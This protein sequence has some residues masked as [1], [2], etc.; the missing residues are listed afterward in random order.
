MAGKGHN[1]IP[2]EIELSIESASINSASGSGFGVSSGDALKSNIDSPVRIELGTKNLILSRSLDKEGAEGESGLTVIVRCARLPSRNSGNNESD[3]KLT[4]GWSNYAADEQS[5]V[6]PLRIIV[7]DANDHHPQF[8]GVPYVA[9]VSEQTPPGS[10]LLPA[11]RVRAVDGDQQGPFSTVQYFVMPG[12]FSHLV[13]FESTLGG[14]L[15]LDSPLDFETQPRV[16]VQ[17]KACDQGEPPN[18]A[19]E[20]ASMTMMVSTFHL[21]NMFASL[22]QVTI[23]VQDAD[24][25]NPRFVDEKYSAW[26]P[27]KNRV[28]DKLDLFP[29]VIKAIDPDVQIASQI[30]YELSSVG[31]AQ[32]GWE[33]LH[34]YL[35]ING[36]GEVQLSRSLPAHLL[37]L[38]ITLVIRATQAD[39]RDRYA[40]TTLSILGKRSQ[41]SSS[42]GTTDGAGGQ[43]LISANGGD[44]ASSKLQFISKNYS[45]I[46]A[47]NA[48]P[49]QIVVTVQVRR[50]SISSGLATERP[51]SY[52]LLDDNEGHFTIATNGEIRLQ[53]SLDYEHQRS[54]VFRVLASDGVQSDICNV[55]VSVQDV[56][57]HDPQFAQPYYA[58]YVPESKLRSNALV[59]ELRATDGDEGD[60]VRLSIRGPFAGHFK[61]LPNGQLRLVTVAGL[62]VSQCHLIVQATD[63]GNPPR[64]SSVPVSVQLPAN[65]LL[66]GGAQNGLDNGVA[67]DEN[68]LLVNGL[69]I[70]DQP[71]MD[72]AQRNDLLTV[73]GWIDVNALFSSGSAS[74]VVLIVVL[75]VLLAI[76]LIIII[77]L[78]VH[79]LRQRKLAHDA[80]SSI[81]NS[82]QDSGTNSP[83]AGHHHGGLDDLGVVSHLNFGTR[84]YSTG[85]YKHGGS[86]GSRCSRGSGGGVSPEPAAMHGSDTLAGLLRNSTS[87]NAGLANGFGAFRVLDPNNVARLTEADSAIASDASS[88]DGKP[89]M[90]HRGGVCSGGSG[91]GG[92]IGDSG[93][94]GSNSSHSG[95]D[96]NHGFT[97]G[98]MAKLHRWQ[99]NGSIPRRVKKLTWEDERLGTHANSIGVLSPNVCLVR[100]DCELDPD[101][102]VAPL[103]SGSTLYHQHSDKSTPDVT[104]Y[105]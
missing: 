34:T 53:K 83:T 36:Q 35:K 68:D 12:P 103:R 39:N 11:G 95:H 24:D 18:C 22:N 64:S 94:S 54:H 60:Q 99:A 46:C 1:S 40:L 49:E 77:T 105:F 2:A 65:A 30:E 23:N 62:N 72:R 6:I 51:I 10:A 69:E 57:D 56:N 66:R 92:G 21:S 43:G 41:A 75:A 88:N 93:C 78:S 52:Q 90:H 44:P 33:Q 86:G 71:P 67:V 48:P 70:D 100:S 27:E 3:N 58:F 82:T 104:V 80:V 47:E 79:V 29:R 9:N 89:M 85:L 31:A 26:L 87:L 25:Q 28:G 19:T 38:P 7:T 59:G 13:R 55:N 16:Q 37:Q 84:F 98:L 5:S 76:L 96:M 97:G 91:S 101:V 63:T 32:P 20:Q 45:A 17:I 102:S 14:A 42:T 74:V 73:G 8:V 81:S 4:S 61:I 15:L 50:P